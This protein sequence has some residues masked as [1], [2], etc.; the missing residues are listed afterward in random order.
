MDPATPRILAPHLEQFKHHAGPVRILGK[1]TQ[2]RGEE[3]TIDASGQITLRLNR[4]SK[5]D[6]LKDGDLCC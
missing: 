6:S 2:L 5:F 3:A 4:V 1:V